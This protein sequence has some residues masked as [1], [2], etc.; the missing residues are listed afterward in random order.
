[1]TTRALLVHPYFPGNLFWTHRK[2]CEAVGAK[3]PAAPLGLVTVAAMLPADWE[4]R[5]VDRNTPNSATRVSR[6]LTS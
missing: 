3:H 6:G 4:V 2:T 5:L 1:M